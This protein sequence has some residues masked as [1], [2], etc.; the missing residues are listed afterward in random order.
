[1][2]AGTLLGSGRTGSAGQSGLPFAPMGRPHVQPLFGFHLHPSVENAAA[3]EYERV[4]PVVINDGQL[5]IAVERRGGY[6]LPHRVRMTAES[7]G[8]LT[9]IMLCELRGGGRRGGGGKPH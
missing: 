2:S 1:M 9:Y 7:T 6:L 3:R 5:K 4:R 8:A